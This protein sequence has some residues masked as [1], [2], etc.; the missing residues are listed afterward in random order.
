M[1]TGHRQRGLHGWAVPGPSWLQGGQGGVGSGGQRRGQRGVVAGRLPGSRADIQEWVHFPCSGPAAGDLL[2][3]APWESWRQGESQSHP[4]RE[5]PPPL[6]ISGPIF[7]VKKVS[8]V[9]ANERVLE[10]L[11]TPILPLP[12][13]PGCPHSHSRPERPRAQVAWRVTGAAAAATGQGGAER[14][15]GFASR[16]VWRP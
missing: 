10:V 14:P 13:L 9:N 1:Q 6:V 5:P 15:P 16:R 4:S 3:P 12:A 2:P 11:V 8:V 7:L